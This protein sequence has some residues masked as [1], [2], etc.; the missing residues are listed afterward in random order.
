MSS[1]MPA[2]PNTTSVKKT[3]GAFNGLLGFFSKNSTKQTGGS[4]RKRK[5]TRK[6]RKHRR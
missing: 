4:R 3:P 5:R 2:A 1:V 6:V